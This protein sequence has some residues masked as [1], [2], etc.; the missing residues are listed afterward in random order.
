MPGSLN[1]V[2]FR[3]API[4]RHHDMGIETRTAASHHLLRAK[5]MRARNF[6][7]TIILS[8]AISPLVHAQSPG[9]FQSL[10]YAR[11]L[12]AAGMG[13]QGVASNNA[14][15]AMQYNPANLIYSNN[16]GISFF[17]N[18]WDIFWFNAP[19][20]AWNAS[21]KFEDGSSVGLDYT[22]QNFGTFVMTDELANESR[23]HYFERSVAAAYAM[24]FGEHFAAGV[25]ARYAWLPL[26][27]GSYIQHLLISAGVTARPADF[28]NRLTI[29]FSLMNFSSVVNDR[30]GT[31]GGINIDETDSPPSQMNLG[32]EA[33]AVTNDFFDLKLSLGAMKPIVKREG[34]PGYGAENSLSA[35]FNDWSDF[36]NDVTAEAGLGFL[37]HPINLGAGV[38]LLQE[39]YLG[40]F[41][42]GPADFQNS[43]A[44]H[45]VSIGL[46]VHGIRATAGYAGRWHNYRSDEYV[47]WTFPWET[48]QFCLSG[49]MNSLLRDDAQ[50]TTSSLLRYMIL[51]AGFTY[52]DP[53]GIFNQQRMEG[54][55]LSW[56]VKG[57]WSV[58]SDF[59]FSDNSAL[60]T[61]FRYSRLI[62]SARVAPSPTP[63]L[64]YPVFFQ[65]EIPAET[66]SLESG[67]RYH[68]IEEL[69]PLF[70]QASL[71]I[72][73]IN[74]IPETSPRYFYKSFD[75]LVIGFVIPA[76]NT[77]VQILPK[78]GLKTIFMEIPPNADRLGGYNQFTLGVSVGYQL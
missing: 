21:W 55:L 4:K 10:T 40:Y 54:Y 34:A 71:G 43:F 46:E 74:P 27:S 12:P 38:S 36:P 18:P 22:Y 77:G 49:D 44:T 9:I 75:E 25:Q 7:L 52:G 32:V 6:I 76:G 70:I 8:A 41:T 11:S 58:E 26:S 37:W 53:V 73:R 20:T 65:L 30:G 64:P 69:H 28:A 47:I 2:F 48:F 15:D 39:M 13:E 14:L 31:V 60:H 3:I 66:V 51:S 59:Y 5:T 62:E 68:P 19:L 78:A 42:T 29:G 67:Y 35:L 50:K 1:R 57:N 72:I 24:P 63:P 23:Y 56:S 45:G 61:A 33:A 16:W 17:N